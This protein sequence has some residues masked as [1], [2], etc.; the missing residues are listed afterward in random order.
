MKEEIS[1]VNFNILYNQSITENIF[2]I[3]ERNIQGWKLS[4]LVILEIWAF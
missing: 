1:E 3:A 4:S 2:L